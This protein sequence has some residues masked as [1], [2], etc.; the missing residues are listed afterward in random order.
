MKAYIFPGQGSQFSGM[1]QDLYDSSSLARQMF[2]EANAILGF[3]I[4]DIMFGGSA[5]DLRRTDVT[6]PAVF[7]HSVIAERVAESEGAS[8]P[9]MV[10]GHSLGEYSAL[11]VSGV[12][13]F[14]DAI[15]LV[16][17]RALAMQQACETQQGT[18]AAV[19]RMEDEVVKQTCEE[20]D[21][22]VVAA[23]FN[24]PGQ[25]V[26]S[27]TIT[28]IEKAKKALEEKGGKR[29]I[30]LSV[31]GAFHSPLMQPAAQMLEKAIMQTQ[32][33]TPACPIFQNVSATAQTD[34][35]IIKRNL[36]AQLT[37]P[38]RWTETINNMIEEGATS[39]RE[40]GPGDVLKGLVRK[41]NAEIEVE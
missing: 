27:G 8:R 3:R 5:D 41:I 11:A 2:E 36:V 16:H 14:S 4:T 24:C 23:N 9:D 22:I 26:I 21:D 6:Q 18:M 15:R 30:T 38:V 28:G 31:G 34:P 12:L 40:F 20:I 29:I 33:N 19:L 17:A 7:I 39:F 13:S 35:E 25:V 37:A 32:F 1:G 10:A